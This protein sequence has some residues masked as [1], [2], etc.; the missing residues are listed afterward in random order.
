MMRFVQ[1]H[2]SN[3]LEGLKRFTDDIDKRMQLNRLYE[4]AQVARAD[5]V[6][7]HLDKVSN[8][9]VSILS[10]VSRVNVGVKC[11]K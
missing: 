2:L 8:S 9:L 4:E 5:R 6:D 1:V 11:E 3:Y 7:E 10:N